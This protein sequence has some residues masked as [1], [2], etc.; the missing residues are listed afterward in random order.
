MLMTNILT[1]VALV[2]LL[3]IVPMVPAFFMSKV[4]AAG[5]ASVGPDEGPEAGRSALR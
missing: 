1:L 2:V 3:T 4:L 5:L